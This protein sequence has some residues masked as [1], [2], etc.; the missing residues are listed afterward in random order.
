MKQEW[1]KPIITIVKKSTTEENVLWAC[2]NATGDAP[3]PGGPAGNMCGQTIG[4]DGHGVQ[5][6]N[7][8]NIS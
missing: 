2:K 5:Y 3:D 6:C 7:P 8:A 4:P 1:K